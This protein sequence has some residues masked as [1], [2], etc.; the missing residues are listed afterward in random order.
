MADLCGY[1]MHL[2]A[3][4]RLRET[5]FRE[6]N[7]TDLLLWSVLLGNFELARALRR[8]CHNP[9]RAA[10]MA[11]RLCLKLKDMC[12]TAVEKELRDAADDFED[13]GVGV[14]DQITRSEDAVDMLT[15]T[16]TRCERSDLDRAHS[17]RHPGRHRG[18]N[19]AEARYIR[20]WPGSL[21][22]SNRHP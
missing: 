22:D 16:P 11:R 12:G 20:L 1:R 2:R 19:G 9:L 3:R 7:F 18:A 15:C 8:R 4:S 17:G 13:W 5:V 10:V 14:L 21:P 6:P